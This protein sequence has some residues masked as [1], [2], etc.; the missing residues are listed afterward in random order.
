MKNNLI[1]LLLCIFLIGM[2]SG[3]SNMKVF[4][5]K[6][7]SE[8]F[9]QFKTFEFLGWSNEIDQQLSPFDKERIEESFV[10]EAAKRGLSGVEKDGDIIVTL[11]VTGEVRTKQTAT[12]TTTGMGMGTMGGRGRGMRSPG[13]GWGG[14]MAV[15]QSHTVINET[16]YL[17]GTLMLE[18]F[19]REDKKLIFQAMGTKTVDQDP[20]K[21]QKQ[22]PKLVAEIM[23][24]YPVEPEK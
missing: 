23:K 19:D 22:L 4:S 18:I 7:N 10:M 3:C 11:F 2:L 13:W 17:V 21:R 15:T 20:Q 8:D 24:E 12:T 1:Y 14:G 5:D 16:N 9:T 6:D